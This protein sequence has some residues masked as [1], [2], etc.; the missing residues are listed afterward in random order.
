MGANSGKHGRADLLYR[1]LNKEAE[2]SDAVIDDVRLDTIT[3]KVMVYMATL[4]PSEWTK[5]QWSLF[6]RIFTARQ[7]RQRQLKT[8][9][10]LP[11][12]SMSLNQLRLL[13]K[14]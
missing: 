11:V 7:N 14:K 6:N 2:P 13:A 5:D 8:P 3:E 1:E 4:E 10:N 9:G 12:S